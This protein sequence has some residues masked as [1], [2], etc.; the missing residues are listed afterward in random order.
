MTPSDASLR[1]LEASS[2]R[3]FVASAASRLT[4]RVLDYGAGKQP[5]R[6]IVEGAGGEYVPYDRIAF[7]G[8]VATTDVGPD[9]P[10]IRAPNARG[11]RDPEWDAILCTQ[12]LQYVP[13]PKYLI[14]SFREAL[15]VGGVLVMTYPT[16]WPEIEAVDL[17]R[18]TTTGIR[19]MLEEAGFVV[20]RIE[21]R[22]EFDLDGFRLSLGGGVEA[23]K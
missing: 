21:R 23:F 14:E 2:I 10:L 11:V 8:S 16:T 18:F 3:E 9:Y 1:E 12:V 19:R 15:V 17:R 22:G 7:P 6:S 20:V 5:Y 13:D 4:G